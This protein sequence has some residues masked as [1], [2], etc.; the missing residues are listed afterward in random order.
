MLT[1]S[2][3]VQQCYLHYIYKNRNI[4][5]FGRIININIRSSRICFT[6]NF[7]GTGFFTF[8][9]LVILTPIIAVPLEILL[10]PTGRE[11]AVAILKST[12]MLVNGLLKVPKHN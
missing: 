12:G 5:S 4:S 2:V 9:F 7:A 6:F 11:R 8:A 3:F 1:Y 10:N